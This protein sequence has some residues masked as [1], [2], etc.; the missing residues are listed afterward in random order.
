MNP[1]A[2]E[3]Q[4]QAPPESRRRSGNLY[5]HIV[6]KT[7][8]GVIHVDPAG[9]ILAVNS[10]FKDLLGYEHSEVGGRSFTE[11]LAPDHRSLFEEAMRQSEGSQASRT[12]PPKK[13]ITRMM[14]VSLVS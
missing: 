5:T 12:A 14:S 13:S 11:F 8:D 4:N 9:R 6:D 3:S 2:T 10:A 1:P 7:S